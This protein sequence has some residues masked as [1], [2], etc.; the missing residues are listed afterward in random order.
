LYAQAQELATKTVV[1]ND[2]DDDPPAAK[3]T[4]KVPF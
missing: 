4:D 3:Q 2:T 1:N